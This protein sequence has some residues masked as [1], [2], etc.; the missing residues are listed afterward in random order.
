MG[1]IKARLTVGNWVRSG[2]ELAV[3]GMAAAMI[4]FAIG[5]ILGVAV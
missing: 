3:I 4:G 1:A 2:I 5:S